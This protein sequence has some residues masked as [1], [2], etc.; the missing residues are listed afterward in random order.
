MCT[1][2][3]ITEAGLQNIKAKL[4]SKYL[5]IQKFYPVKLSQMI[6]QKGSKYV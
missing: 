3:S 6:S 5:R 4:F 2:V 1:C